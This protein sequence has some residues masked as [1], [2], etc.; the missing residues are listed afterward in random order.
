MGVGSTLGS[1]QSV[2]FGAIDIQHVGED[3]IV[4]DW[5]LED[6]LAFMQQAGLVGA[7]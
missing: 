1:G 7:S 5:H 2:E 6:N 3:R 4:E